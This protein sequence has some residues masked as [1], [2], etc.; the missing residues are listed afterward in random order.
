M[1]RAPTPCAE[2]GCPQVAGP[3]GRC[4][5]HTR[6]VSWSRGQHGR[7]MPARWA[8]TRTRILRRD[9]TCRIRGPRCTLISTDVDHIQPG[10]GDSDANLQGTC[11]PCHQDKTQQEAL[12]GRTKREDSF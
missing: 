2:T 6:P 12:A 5:A 3:G 1:T 10:G 8:K 11:R 7:A 4:P 9:P